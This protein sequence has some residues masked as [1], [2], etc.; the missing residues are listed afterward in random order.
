MI[1]GAGSYS[2]ANLRRSQMSKNSE[3][4]GS[5]E[6]GR[7]RLNGFLKEFTSNKLVLLMVGAALTGLVVPYINSKRLTEEIRLKKALEI[8]NHNLEFNRGFNSLKT[9]LTTFYFDNRRRV[10][11]RPDEWNSADFRAEQVRFNKEMNT[12]YAE[13]DKQTWFWYRGVLQEAQ[14]LGLIPNNS[15]NYERFKC[16][17]AA[18]D[19]NVGDSVGALGDF[20]HN[21]V[22]PHYDPK[23]EYEAEKSG[24]RI[25]AE[26][27]N[28]T[29]AT[30]KPLFEAR[31]KLVDEMADL[32]TE[33]RHI[34]EGAPCA[35]LH[36]PVGRS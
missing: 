15:W 16:V 14:I 13:F 32:F 7:G 20:W 19:K 5:E 22:S 12:Q 11:A 36:Q 34:K 27:W 24:Q 28:K 29:D 30:L 10:E 18:Y 3:E 4:G 26:L 6:S 1:R 25:R 35:E 21:I 23:V 9:A 31:S 33:A 2:N 8:A 17:A